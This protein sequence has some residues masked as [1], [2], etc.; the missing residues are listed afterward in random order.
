MSKIV[1]S[2]EFTGGEAIFGKLK[3][4]EFFTG[5]YGDEF[6]IDLYKTQ[7]ASY[8]SY[9]DIDDDFIACLPPRD[10][11]NKQIYAEIFEIVANGDY[12]DDDKELNAYVTDEYKEVMA[13]DELLDELDEWGCRA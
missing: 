10:E 12:S 7:E 11:L 3:T 6:I 8:E 4:G 13:N 5:N 2:L 1:E 9:G